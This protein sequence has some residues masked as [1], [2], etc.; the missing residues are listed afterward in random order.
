MAENDEKRDYTDG[1][2]LPTIEEMSGSIHYGGRMVINE[3]NEPAI[4][5]TTTNNPVAQ[6]TGVR[7]AETVWRQVRDSLN[8]EGTWALAEVD[9]FRGFF[10]SGWN[11]RGMV[12]ML[13]RATPDSS[14]TERARRV[15]YALGPMIDLADLSDDE[16]ERAVTIIATEFQK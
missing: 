15:V 16:I 2:R 10:I 9:V 3:D 1:G 8:R 4:E 5:V 6:P 12:D 7:D 11:H 14:I 13:N